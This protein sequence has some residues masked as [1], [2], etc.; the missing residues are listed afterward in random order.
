M[1]I[2]KIALYNS[3]VGKFGQLWFSVNESFYSGYL[4]ARLLQLIVSYYN[5]KVLIFVV[6][7]EVDAAG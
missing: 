1:S 6:K 2:V 4:I 7:Q 3:H 5:L